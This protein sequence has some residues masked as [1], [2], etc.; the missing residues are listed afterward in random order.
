MEEQISAIVRLAAENPRPKD[1]VFTYGTAGFRLKG[2]LLGSVVFGVG[3]L[4]SLRSRKL[5]G[6]VIG[7]MITASH[8]PPDDNGVKLVD[9]QGEMLEASWE[10]YA[11]EFANAA[12]GEDLARAYS[13]LARTLK[14]DVTKPANVAFA[15]DT[16]SSGPALANSLQN[17]LNATQCIMTDYGVLTTPQLHYIVKALNSVNTSEPYG[18]PT[19]EG[20]YIKLSEAFKSC[21]QGKSKCSIKVDAA[22]GVGGPQFK[23]LLGYIG[24]DLLEA[25]IFNDNVVAVDQLNHGCGADFVKTQQKLPLGLNPEP[26]DLYASFD[27][28]ADRIVFYFVD[29]SQTFN[30][31]DGDK[32]ASISAMFI[33]DLLKRAGINLEVGVVQTAYANGSSTSYLTDVLKVPVKIT[34]TGVKNL[35]QAAR[36]F[37]I[38]VYFEANGHGTVLFSPSASRAL[39]EYEAHSPGEKAAIDTLIALYNLINQAIGDAVSDL[40]LV[41]VILVDKALGPQEWISTYTDLPNRLAKVVVKD[42]HAFKSEDAERK[43]VEPKGIQPQIDDLMKKYKNGRSFVRASGTEDVVR[44]YAEA[45]TRHEADE[46]AIKVA[47][48][49]KD[50]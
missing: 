20:Y 11:T 19:E 23:K 39:K 50:Y 25:T 28:D 40:L 13:E 38:G 35:D 44:V 2:H 16:R 6:K 14:I 24:S 46:L 22:N 18:K 27:G 9:P 49:L 29:E 31:L 21:M 8:N 10:T 42:R 1:M 26:Y 17:G 37:D 36:S 7:V 33:C 43:L 3:L 15:R 30:L 47:E 32:I 45:A 5:D 12:T 41:L 48:L 34:P 4:A